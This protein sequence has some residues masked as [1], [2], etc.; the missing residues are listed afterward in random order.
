M[1]ELEPQIRRYAREVNRRTEPVSAHQACGWDRPRPAGGRRWQLVAAALVVMAA[2]AAGVGWLVDRSG[3]GPLKVTDP[4]TQVA[5]WGPPR[6]LMADD[7]A[8]WIAFGG[9]AA[10]GQPSAAPGGIVR[11][12]VDR[13]EFDVV[14]QIPALSSVAVATHP[15]GTSLWAARWPG[16]LVRLN[17]ATG[18]V[19]A[20][21]DLSAAPGLDGTFRPNGVMAT[22]QAVWVTTERGFVAVVDTARNAVDDVVELV[23]N[24]L[25]AGVARGPVAWI[26]QGAHGL[27]RVDA[28]ASHPVQTF[29][30]E[31]AGSG[32]FRAADVT[33]AEDRLWIAGTI[34]D[35]TG[36]IVAVDPDSGD[37][38]AQADTPEP[39]HEVAVVNDRVWARADS[40]SPGLWHAPTDLDGRQTARKASGLPSPVGTLHAAHDALW[41][42]DPNKPALLRLNGDTGEPINTILLPP[43][44]NE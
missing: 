36:T 23:P 38:H 3:P 39:V 22:G 30:P 41:A 31:V 27:A 20:R 42:L 35:D 26:V 1:P 19:Q 7:E 37:V 10:G 21:I 14:A 12:D 44:T 15:E 40:D 17:A 16:E 33:A 2:A 8:V 34:G 43:A 9:P 4:P 6:E 24:Q 18:D 5:D 25:R 29:D 11:L 28:L 32:S 13:G